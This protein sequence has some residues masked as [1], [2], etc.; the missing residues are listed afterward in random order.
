MYCC[1]N[2]HTDMQRKE[3]VDLL[4]E[5]GVNEPDEDRKD[6][7]TKVGALPKW[8]QDWVKESGLTRVKCRRR[9]RR[10]RSSR[11]RRPKRKRKRGR[12][13]KR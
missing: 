2:G 1:E 8:M 3:Y 6:I 5:N 4:V 11:R 10:R 9:R 13:A 7:K 12:S